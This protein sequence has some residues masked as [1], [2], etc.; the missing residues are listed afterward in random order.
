MKDKIR[1][2]LDSYEIKTIINALNDLRNK[3]KEQNISTDIVDEILLK[4]IDE[5]DKK[6]QFIKI[7]T[8]DNYGKRY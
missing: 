6:K 1:L 8:R 5:I 4:L 3:S 2:E 7:L